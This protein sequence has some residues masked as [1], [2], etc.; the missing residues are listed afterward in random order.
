MKFKVVEAG[1]LP[2]ETTVIARIDEDSMHGNNY[3]VVNADKPY[4]A[5]V[6]ALIKAH[7]PHALLQ[8]VFET[9]RF[10][11]VSIF[12]R[13]AYFIEPEKIT[14]TEYIH[15]SYMGLFLAETHQ[16]ASGKHKL[17]LNISM[18]FEDLEEAHK[19][20]TVVYTLFA[21]ID[22]MKRQGESEG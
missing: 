11:D 10:M 5:T 15:R 20:A 8:V 21:G 14:A 18:N 3:L 16:L 4:A 7:H 9:L 1:S 2:K 13:K 19:W 22:A 6:A 17:D 12:E